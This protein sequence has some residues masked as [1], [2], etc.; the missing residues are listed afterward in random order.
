MVDSL[1]P[2]LDKKGK[3][4]PVSKA[5]TMGTPYKGSFEAVIKIAT[6]TGQPR[7]G[8]AHLASVKRPINFFPVSSIARA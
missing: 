4:A 5:V 7:F 2:L 1:L 3:S 8:C 6:G